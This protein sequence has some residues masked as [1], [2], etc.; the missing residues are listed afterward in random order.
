MYISNFLM[1]EILL[2]KKFKIDLGKSIILMNYYSYFPSPHITPLPNCSDRTMIILNLRQRDSKHFFLFKLLART[3]VHFWTYGNVFPRAH[4]QGGSVACMFFLPAC[5]SVL[6][7]TSSATPANLLVAS[8]AAS[9]IPFMHL[10][11]SRGRMPGFKLDTS[12]TVS[13]GAAYSTTLKNTIQETLFIM[14]NKTKHQKHLIK[15]R[16]YQIVVHNCKASDSNI[17]VQC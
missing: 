17:F 9:C 11:S 10:E 14:R 6:M 4:S 2:K 8:M 3:Q 12:R 7:S 5:N 16:P 15:R 13:R 1:I